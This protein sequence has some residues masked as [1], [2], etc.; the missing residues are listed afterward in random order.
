M[1][2]YAAAGLDEYAAYTRHYRQCMQLGSESSFLALWSYAGEIELERAFHKDLY[3]HTAIWQGRRVWYPPVGEWMRPDWE[4]LLTEYVPPGTEFCF[5]P[6]FLVQLWRKQFGGRIVIEDMREE[7]DYLYS[8]EQQ[9]G[10]EGQAFSSIRR[11][12]RKFLESNNHSYSL[13]TP[14]EIPALLEFQDKWMALN[15]EAGKLDD[16]LAAEHRTILKFFRH[17]HELRDL[18]GA[19]LK[20]DGKV[21][22]YVFSEALEDYMLSGHL[23]KGYYE[24][25][26]V[27]QAMNLLFYKN[28]LSRFSISND[29]GDG[30]YEN[31]RQAK[32]NFNPI[33]FIR[34]YR[35]F[36]DRPA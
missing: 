19:L 18:Y 28:T 23:L 8:I 14:H 22:A 21:V 30:G 3:W 31:L 9:I 34:K 35:V 16:S 29:W 1:R 32:L 26:G 7:W 2:F 10:L 24:Y 33:G 17:W 13:I 15:A 12:C 25:T 27:Y 11:K 20:V 4:A 36:W 5:M 6:E